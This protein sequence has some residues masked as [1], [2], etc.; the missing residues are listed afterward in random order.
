MKTKFYCVCRSSWEGFYVDSFWKSKPLA[1]KRCKQKVQ[2]Q[3]EED[4]DIEDVDKWYVTTHK[5]ED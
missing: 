5:F 1:D 2:E 3:I 4:P